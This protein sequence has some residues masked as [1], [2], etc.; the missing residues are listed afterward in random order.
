MWSL[1]IQHICHTQER[2]HEAP[3]YRQ[4]LDRTALYYTVP[5]WGELVRKVLLYI[6]KSGH[7]PKGKI[8]K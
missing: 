3:Q 8:I 2:P 5:R 6:R 7:Q 4:S 1:G